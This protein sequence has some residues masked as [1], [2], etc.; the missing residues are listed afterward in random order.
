MQARH[1]YLV[2]RQFCP[3]AMLWLDPD[4][5]RRTLKIDELTSPMSYNFTSQWE[6]NS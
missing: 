4:D 2:H 1:V 3:P 6:K 5:P